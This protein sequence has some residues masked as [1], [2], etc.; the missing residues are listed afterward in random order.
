[1]QLDNLQKD[2]EAL[3][4]LDPLWAVLSDPQKKFGKWDLTEF[5]NTG[6]REIAEL[7]STVAQLGYPLKLDAA[8]DFGC[9]VG[10]LTKA[11]SE[12]FDKAIGVDISEVMLS[13]ARVYANKCSF[14]HN[15]KDNLDIFPDNSFDLVYSSIVLQHLPSDK[16][17]NA[18]LSE[19]IR[20]LK[21]G[22]LLA[23]QLP[24]R[25]PWWWRFRPDKKTYRILRSAG[26]GEKILFSW[27]LQPMS[28]RGIPQ[29]EIVSFLERGHTR[30][31]KAEADN[32]AGSFIDSYIYYAHKL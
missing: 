29:K 32:R 7:M 1:M 22:G 9:G 24:S 11:L 31:L 20:I 18:Y 6:E 26:I 5:F 3:G 15:N 10:R 12:R 17:I 13:R 19:F 8:L 2:W 23:F 30:I 28:M 25:V 16:V 21:P 4:D 27:G 14:F